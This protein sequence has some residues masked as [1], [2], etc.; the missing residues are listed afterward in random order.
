MT[1]SNQPSKS[2]IEPKK[3]VKSLFSEFL[4][5]LVEWFADL[6]NLQ[7]GMD[8][9][10]TIVAIRTNK[11]IR[12]ASAWLLMCS[13]VIASLGLDLN[14]PAVIIGAMLISPLMSPILGVGLGIAVNDK[15]GAFISLQHFTVAILIALFA[16]TLYFLITPFGELTPE[17]EARTAPTLLDGLV[18]VFGGV[19]GIISVSRKD[20]SSAI[21]G[22]AIATALMPPLCVTG[23]GLANANW[24][25][26]L[27]SF[28][29][30][31]LNSFFISTSTFLIIR[32]LQFPLKTY[33]DEDEGRRT[34]LILAIF[35]LILI[36]PSAKILY[37]L[38]GQRQ[39]ERK[40]EAFISD[41]FTGT[42]G[43]QSLDY[44][45]IRK[46]STNRLVLQLLGK[47]VAED[48]VKQLENKLPNYGLRNTKLTLIQ[49]SGISVEELDRLQLEFSNDLE[50]IEKRLTG[51]DSEKTNTQ[52]ELEAL[53]VKLDSLQ[54]DTIAFEKICNQA[55][56]VFPELRELSYGKITQSRFDSTS[57]LLPTFLIKWEPS[58]PRSQRR[59]DEKKLYGLL[60]Y[61][62]ELDTFQMVSY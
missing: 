22:V 13:I 39:D 50:K 43:T 52:R 26:A 61:A 16:S 2:P 31:F 62:A 5:A 37:D 38:Y 57:T 59:I 25:V 7:E 40:V 32:Y 34:K 46:D 20:K 19:A 9:E 30:F 14:S 15:E 58:K 27:N 21:P 33:L 11:R 42:N 10:G 55:K 54:R 36:L 60:K 24:Q 47:A 41:H 23:Y 8:R 3:D 48:S 18:A 6:I 17:I 56:A 49:S 53:R 45:L 35:S 29:L 44:R 1:T 51:A 4:D 28:Y 12:G